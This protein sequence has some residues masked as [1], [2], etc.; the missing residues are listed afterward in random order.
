V[1]LASTAP[2]WSPGRLLFVDDAQQQRCNKISAAAHKHSA[3][4]KG[5]MPAGLPGDCTSHDDRDAIGLSPAPCHTRDTATA[6]RHELSQHHGKLVRATADAW[7]APPPHTHTYA[8]A[9]LDSFK[10]LWRR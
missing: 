8:A 1:P 6:T 2:Q 10:R 9:L 5:R 7:T 4:G 3:S